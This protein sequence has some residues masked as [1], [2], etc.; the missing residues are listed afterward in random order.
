[1]RRSNER[2]PAISL[3]SASTLGASVVITCFTSAGRFV[4]MPDSSVYRKSGTPEGQVGTPMRRTGVVVATD[5]VRQRY[6]GRCRSPYKPDGSA[7]IPIFGSAVDFECERACI[8]KTAPVKN[9]GG[10][11]IASGIGRI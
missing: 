9:A 11:P 8:G 1:M 4:M 5:V 10:W 6:V 2:T 3:P 7:A